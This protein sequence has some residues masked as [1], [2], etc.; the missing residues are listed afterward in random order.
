MP[1]LSSGIA[2]PGSDK[3]YKKKIIK[4]ESTP[5][6]VSSIP[7]YFNLVCVRSVRLALH[8]YQYPM[9]APNSSAG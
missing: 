7:K 3:K 8:K 5:M 2:G 9:K 4:L 1:S 6:A